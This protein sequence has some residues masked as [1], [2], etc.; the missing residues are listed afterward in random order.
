MVRDVAPHRHDIL[1]RERPEPHRHLA[2]VI[3]EKQR[4]AVLAAGIGR[5]VGESQR[6]AG[7]REAMGRPENRQRRR[8]NR[9]AGRAHLVLAAGPTVL[10]HDLE[11]HHRFDALSRVA[12]SV[13]RADLTSTVPV[14]SPKAP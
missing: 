2:L 10:I 5:I 8:L 13:G 3:D 7:G 9:D 12:V 4:E 11:S 1:L 14:V 6:H